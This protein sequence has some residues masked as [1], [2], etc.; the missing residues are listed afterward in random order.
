V[1]VLRTELQS[2]D[3]PPDDPLLPVS[4]PG[5]AHAYGTLLLKSIRG[6]QVETDM[7]VSAVTFAGDRQFQALKRRFKRVVQ[8]RAYRR[9]TVYG[10]TGFA[11]LLYLTA[12]T[13][14]FQQ[15]YARYEANE[16]IELYSTAGTRL[17]VE[18]SDELRSAISFDDHQLYICGDQ[19][20][21][22]IGA[23][24]NQ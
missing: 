6:L 3:A 1:A 16:S 17:L 10:M 9:M 8:Y 18:D 5:I 12:L 15:P 4:G 13:I 22:H 14:I 11:A 21:G 23:Q 20:K 24:R 19:L 7:A 2:G